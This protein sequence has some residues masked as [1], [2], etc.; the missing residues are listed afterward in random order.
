M[1]LNRFHTVF[2]IISIST[3]ETV[4]WFLDLRQDLFLFF[5]TAVFITFYYWIL[6][7]NLRVKGFTQE[8]KM[9]YSKGLPFQHLWFF[10]YKPCIFKIRI[11][12]SVS[13]FLHTRESYNLLRKSIFH[14]IIVILIWNL[15]SYNLPPTVFVL[16]P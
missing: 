8:E 5:D 7:Q 2:I 12:S 9:T 11:L 14:N 16:T 13:T 6:L 4:L 15:S 1:V 3:Q 10:R